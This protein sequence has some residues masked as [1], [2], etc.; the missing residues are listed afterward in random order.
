MIKKISLGFLAAIVLLVIAILVQDVDPIQYDP[1]E[2][3]FLFPDSLVTQSFDIDSLK[4]VVGS[5]KG[6][7]EG[8]ELAALLA[9]SAYPQLKDVAIDMKLIPSGAPMEANFDIPT[10]FGKGKNRK[11]IIYLNNATNTPFDEILLYSLPFDAQVGILAHELGHTVYYHQL[12]TLQIAK[13]GLMYAIDDDFRATHERS[14]DLM[15][16]YHGL[17]SQIYQY[18]WYVRYDPCCVD[19]YERYGQIFMDKYY[20]TDKELADAMRKHKLYEKRFEE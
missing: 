20:M 8:F 15:P 12:T 14:T 17:G 5:N 13:W 11:Y 18:A 6:L 4:E 16:V 2:N 9:Y 1:Q 3:V 19:M 10:L 7:P